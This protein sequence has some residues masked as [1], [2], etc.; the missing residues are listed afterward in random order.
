MAR[1]RGTALLASVRRSRLGGIDR[2]SFELDVPYARWNEAVGTL[3]AMLA[4]AAAQ[5]GHTVGCIGIVAG[6][7]P[8]LVAL[9]PRLDPLA[10]RARSVLASVA[11]HRYPQ[12][13]VTLPP[14]TYLAQVVDPHSAFL[15]DEGRLLG[16]LRVGT[17]GHCV[18]FDV[19]AEAVSERLHLVAYGRRRELSRFLA[20]ARDVLS[21]LPD[22]RTAR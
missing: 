6:E 9:A 5:V 18:Y 3:A 7:E 2:L 11:P 10:E 20:V 17:I 15:L 12:L 14:G 21:R 22:W 8:I 4:Q 13:W 16:Q 1:R 19:T